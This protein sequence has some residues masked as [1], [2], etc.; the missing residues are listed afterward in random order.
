M[1]NCEIGTAD[2]DVDSLIVIS[3]GTR[4]EFVKMASIV[5]A[6]RRRDLDF[7]LVHTGQHY[8]RAM[9]DSFIRA[10]GLR[11]IR[12]RLHAGSGSHAVQTARVLVG[13]ERILR[14]V[15][16]SAVVVEGDTN[17]VLGSALASLKLGI[18]ICHVEAGLRSHDLRMPEE[19]NR[20]LTDHMSS[21][22]FA[23][24]AD[25][26]KNLIKED[27]WGK[28]FV[29]GNTVI[30]ACLKYLKTA[31]TKSTIME[32]IRFDEFALVTLHRT[33]N[34]DNSSVLRNLTKVLEGLSTPVV[35]PVHPRT[36]ENLT[37]SGLL[38]RLLKSNVQILPPVGY[39][40]FLR[41]MQG[42]SYVLTDSGGVQEEATAPNIRKFV[43]VLRQSTDR[44]E[45]VKAGFA[46]LVGANNPHYILRTINSVLDGG[47]EVPTGPSPYGDGKAGLRIADILR[48]KFT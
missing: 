32:R 25:S 38:R 4:P 13:F 26:R 46:R 6:C 36:K 17:S 24:T 41:L 19:H 34:V 20:R 22:L 15:D 42:C 29:T 31:V 47:A 45:S 27:V 2:R 21:I 12:Y 33:E 10:L 3:M 1:E 23:P 11:G 8:D 14:R 5:E 35:F 28:I 30:D 37:K 48:S 18:P 44:P 40:D 43:F 16:A 9:S 7:E 39:F